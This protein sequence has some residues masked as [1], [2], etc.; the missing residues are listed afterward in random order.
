MQR[1]FGELQYLHRAGRQGDKY[2]LTDYL[3]SVDGMGFKS[4][5]NRRKTSV[6]VLRNGMDCHPS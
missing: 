4:E 2:N 3:K 5:H 6:A 1:A